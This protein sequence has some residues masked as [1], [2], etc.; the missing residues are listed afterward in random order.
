MQA[1][2]GASLSPGSGDRE[3]S[4]TE[5]HPGDDVPSGARPTRRPR[6]L[7]ALFAVVAL[8]LYAVDLTTKE[9]AL[10]HLE[11]RGRVP[12]VGDVLGLRL[13]FNPGAAFSLGTDFTVV[14]T[15]VAIVATV[16][17]LVVSRRIG[18]PLWAVALGVLLAGITGNLTDRLFRDPAPFHGHVVDMIELPS[19]PIF[20]VADMCINVAAVLIVVQAFRGVRV[21]GRRDAEADAVG[22]AGAETDA[23]A[24][25]DARIESDTRL[26]ADARTEADEPRD[27]RA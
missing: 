24:E 25:V 6:R 20:N 22:G 19:W 5:P 1:A 2:R 12:L 23:D 7:W 13:A 10:E 14:I 21:D 8:A 17:V 15:V 3:P 4:G 27:G 16:A 26:D 11:G 18:S 9:L